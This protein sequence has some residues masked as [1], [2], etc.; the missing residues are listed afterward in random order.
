MASTSST[1][2]GAST[3]G[4]RT[5]TPSTTTTAVSGGAHEVTYSVSAS[6]TSSCWAQSINYTATDGSVLHES[7]VTLPVSYAATR[8]AGASYMV[9]ATLQFAGT[10]Q[11]A[12][13]ITCTVSVDGI[14]VDSQTVHGAGPVTCEGTVP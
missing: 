5:T 8:P 11:T 13:A 9:N 14:Q 2:A 1:A 7:D 6:C 12:P 4:V 3:T 10:P